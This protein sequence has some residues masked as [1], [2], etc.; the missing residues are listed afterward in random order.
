LKFTFFHPIGK[1]QKQE[2]K[3]CGFLEKKLLQ[4]MSLFHFFAKS[5]HLEQKNA[6]SDQ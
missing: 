5:C 1:K 2:K 4:E 6:V 3:A